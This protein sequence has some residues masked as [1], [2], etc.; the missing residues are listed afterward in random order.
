M[1]SPI[2]VQVKVM[3]ILIIKKG[4]Q[5]FKQQ[6]DLITIFPTI[7]KYTVLYIYM[8]LQSIYKCTICKLIIKW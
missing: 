3:R 5:E 7:M 8:E 1:P 4:K 6:T 2:C